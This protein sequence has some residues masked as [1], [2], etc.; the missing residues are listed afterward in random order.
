T[1]DGTRLSDRLYSSSISV[2]DRLALRSLRSLYS[3]AEPGTFQFQQ[4]SWCLPGMPR[5][6]PHHCDRSE[7]RD[8]GPLSLDR[9]RGGARFSRAGNGRIAKGSAA[10]LCPRGDRCQHTIR[11]TLEG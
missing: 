11:G 2:L 1:Y 8:P 3:T 9:A 4:S 7:S 10:R 5:L 6:R